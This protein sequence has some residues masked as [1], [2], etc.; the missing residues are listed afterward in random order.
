MADDVLLPTTGTGT[1]NVTVGADE[2]SINGTN[3]KVQRVVVDGG[4]AFATGHVQISSTAATLIAAR[5]TRKRVVITNYQ[6]VPIYVGPATVTTTNGF[7]LD[8]GASLV[9]NTTALIQGITAAAYTASGEDT[10]VHY[11]ETYDA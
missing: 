3:V 6:T 4:T 9:L 2:R 11:V 8:P 10:K 1:A 7:R 5:E